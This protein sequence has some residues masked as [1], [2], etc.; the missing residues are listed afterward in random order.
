MK[1]CRICKNVKV[2][3]EFHKNAASRDGH[4]SRC[5]ECRKKESKANYKDNWFDRTVKL[6]SSYCK[7]RDIPFE[8]DAE[9]LESI[10]T[11]YC[12]ISGVKFERGN[13]LSP[14]CPNLDRIINKEG[15][16]KGN[17]HYISAK[18]NRIKDN[19]TIEELESLVEY[20][21]SIKEVDTSK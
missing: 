16:V 12:P 9:Y 14:N 11:D 4:E 1:E 17:V 19:S 3:T 10:W 8:L 7:K 5:K 21:K 2:Y 13:K 18:M 6:K 20:L 15:Y